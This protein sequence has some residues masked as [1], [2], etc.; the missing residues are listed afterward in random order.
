MIRIAAV[1]YLNT[2]PWVY[3]FERTTW[4]Q[5]V[6][7]YLLTPSELEKSYINDECD[8]A[9]LPV[10]ALKNL[11]D[12]R[13]ITDFCIGADG[14]VNSVIIVSH[15]PLNEVSKMYLDYESVTSVALAKL[16][17]TKYFNYNMTFVNAQMGYE[18]IASTEN[19][20]ALIIG[21]RALALRSEFAYVHDL[22]GEWKNWQ[23]L[24]F[25][26]ACWV[27]KPHVEEEFIKFFN[28][29]LA[30]AVTNLNSFLKQYSHPQFDATTIENYLSHHIQYTFDDKKKQAVKLFLSMI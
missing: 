1:S 26:F 23:H 14:D 6:E 21:D 25:A 8:I 19:A 29:V 16:L 30:D 12:Y 18:K 13:L 2:K 28:T 10:A 11:K 9:L 5:P 22:A 17:V 27:C 24:P 20:A 15:K 3:A 7:V 4:P